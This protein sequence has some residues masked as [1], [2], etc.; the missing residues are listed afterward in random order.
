VLFFAHIP[1]VVNRPVAFTLF[2]S[3]VE[4]PHGLSKE[5]FNQAEVQAMSKTT[6]EKA[7][8]RFVAYDFLNTA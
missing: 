1:F 2:H 4:S 8:G 3:S 7:A 6:N 5:F